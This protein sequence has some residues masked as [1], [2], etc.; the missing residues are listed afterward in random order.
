MKCKICESEQVAIKYKKIN[1]YKIK[2]K[3][4]IL[5]CSNCK[6]SFTDP[7]L[8]KK[9][10]QDY[11]NKHQVA[12]NGAGNDS[13]IVEYLDNKQEQW[14]GLGYL[15]RLNGLLKAKPDAKRVLDIGCG[16]GLYL[17]FLKNEG[18]YVEGIELSPWGYNIATNTLGIKVQN[19]L[20]GNLAEPKSKFDVINLY[21]VVEHT[22]DPN[23]F[24]QDLKKWIKKDGI[25][26]INLPN[27]D[28]KISISSNRYW[29]KISPPDHTF[30]FNIESICYLLNK[31]GFH[32][33][34]IST[35]NGCPGES[36]SQLFIGVWFALSK[37]S[38]KIHRAISEVNQ[39]ASKNKYFIT[40]IIKGTRKGAYYFGA[41]LRPALNRWNR[42]NKGEGL[43]I[44]CKLY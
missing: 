10:Y 34:S 3:F 2:R 39:P 6:V 35:N 14:K 37:H 36:L 43:N 28:S 9:E 38:K 17:D 32:P 12:F 16:A 18:F 19:N 30:H 44:V 13:A 21:D 11:H 31:N 1:G 5:E 24:L 29:N 20:I 25:I 4:D 8:S 40:Y 26:M 41:I 27:M 23:G 7:F 42:K 15:D 22:T 33:I